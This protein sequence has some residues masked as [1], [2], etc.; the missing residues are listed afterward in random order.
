MSVM[1]A[2]GGMCVAFWVG[3][4]AGAA[5]QDDVMPFQIVLFFGGIL[6]V[7]LIAIAIYRVFV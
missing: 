6:T 4:I 3:A 1:N 7:A 5:S 2:L